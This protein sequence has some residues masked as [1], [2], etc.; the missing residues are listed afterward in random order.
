M[1]E[2]QNYLTSFDFQYVLIGTATSPQP[3]PA[4]DPAKNGG[5]QDSAQVDLSKVSKGHSHRQHS[6]PYLKTVELHVFKQDIKCLS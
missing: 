3:Q 4:A 1:A 2:C 5:G 6:A